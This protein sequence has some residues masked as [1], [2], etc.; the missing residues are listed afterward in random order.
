MSLSTIFQLH[1]KKQNIRAVAEKKYV[2]P[3]PFPPGWQ[4]IFFS[5]GRRANENINSVG[6][7]YRHTMYNCMGH[8]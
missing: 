7:G 5:R 3:S 6:P 4:L 1:G 8:T 2:P